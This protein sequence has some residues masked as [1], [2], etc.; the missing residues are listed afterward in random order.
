M[1]LFST[2]S[3]YLA[4]IDAQARAK[5]DLLVTQTSVKEGINDQL[6]S[7]NQLAW[8]GAMSCICNRAKEII[9]A[10]MIFG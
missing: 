4:D 2:G 9:N 10:E 5:L 7:E 8:V 6:K 1:T 3:S